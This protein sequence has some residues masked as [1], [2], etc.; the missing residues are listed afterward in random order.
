MVQAL[1]GGRV[2][3]T[4][5][6]GGGIRVPLLVNGLVSRG[7]PITH[8]ALFDTDRDRLE[9]IARLARARLSRTALT[10]HDDVTRALDGAAFVI[11]SIRVGGLAAREHDEAVALAHG[12]VGQETVGPAGFAMAVRT[13]PPM[14]AYARDIARLAPDAWVVN[15]TNPVGIVTQAMQRA[16]DVKIVGICDTPLELFAE[17]AHAC[18]VEFRECSFDYIGL[19]HLGWLREAHYHGETLLSKLWADQEKLSRVYSRPLFPTAYLSTLRLLPTEYVYFYVFPDRAVANTRAAGR[20]RGMHVADLTA[21]LFA[22]LGSAPDLAIELYEQY[23]AERSGSY[24]QIET[25]QQLPTPPSPWAELTGYDRVAYDVIAAI[26]GD[27]NAVVPVN[28]ANAGNIPELETDDVIEVPCAIGTRGI[29]AQS[30]GALPGA[31]RDL[32]T[33][34][35]QYERLTIEASESK[36]SDALVSALAVNPLV[37]SKEIATLLVD[38][39]IL[40]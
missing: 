12:L 13:V 14:M 2:K 39:L 38:Q 21:E 33:R 36:Q 11:T 7:L 4:I 20:T 40:S 37:R 23:L 28:V 22:R 35:K 29:R 30:V 5:I 8:V 3:L 19:N 26:V 18:D 27:T 1:P 10:T 32:V 15:F 16:A 34:V 31:V 24:M 17:V 9:L 25:G 6:G